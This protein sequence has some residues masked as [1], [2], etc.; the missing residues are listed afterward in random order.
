MKTEIFH[1]HALSALHVGVGQAVGVVDLPIARAK[2]TN[3]PLVP[4]SAL[5]G[6]L[7][8]EF[9]G[10]DQALLFG[11]ES[12]GNGE[13]GYAGAMAFGDAHLL[14]LPVRSLGGIMAWATC[15]FV[16]RRYAADRQ[17]A[18]AGN[19]PK[20]PEIALGK[21]AAATTH[22]LAVTGDRAVFE[23]LDL[24]IE[25]GKAQDWAAC[26]APLLF[27]D[28]AAEFVRHFAILSDA[29]FGFL[30]ETATEVRTHIRIN[31]EK[32][33]VEKGALWYEE[34]LPAEAVLWGILGIGPG[35]KPACSA[36]ETRTRFRAGLGAEKLVQIGGKATTGRGLVRF[37]AQGGAV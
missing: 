25:A 35:R 30:A 3:L 15:P 12:I 36:E 10:D 24:S 1:L 22:D 27:S 19:T 7:R 28:D 32:G 23:D 29:D 37:L 2:A 17:R 13:G 18:G 9:C 5:K 20:V 6:V 33:T 31:D 8:D 4:G 11:P 26:L 21:V 34:N 16:L 14:L